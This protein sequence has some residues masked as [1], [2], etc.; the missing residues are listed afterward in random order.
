MPVWPDLLRAAVAEEDEPTVK[1]CYSALYLGRL[2]GDRL[3]RWLAARE[4]GALKGVK[5]PAWRES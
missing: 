4:V 2:T 1:L 3:Y 5:L